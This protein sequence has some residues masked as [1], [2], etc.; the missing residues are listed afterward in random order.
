MD[1]GA[2]GIVSVAV[3]S[4]AVWIPERVKRIFPEV[5]P[6]WNTADVWPPIEMSVLPCVMENGNER[7]PVAKKTTAGSSVATVESGRNAKLTFPDAEEE[8]AVGRRMVKWR[9]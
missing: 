5:V 3:G 9:C 2:A 1:M 4:L 8:A 6:V 7:P